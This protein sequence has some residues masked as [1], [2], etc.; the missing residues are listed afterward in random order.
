MGRKLLPWLDG[1]SIREVCF[2]IDE[3][4]LKER[5]LD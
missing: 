1:S 4:I 5:R 2:G 3:E